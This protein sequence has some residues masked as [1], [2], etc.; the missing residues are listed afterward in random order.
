M[1]ESAMAPDPVE[2][3]R[4]MSLMYNVRS[5]VNPLDGQQYGPNGLGLLSQ[6]V[7]VF[8]DDGRPKGWRVETQGQ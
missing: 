4:A 3:M 6:V 2:R 8:T 5:T 1:D 7:K